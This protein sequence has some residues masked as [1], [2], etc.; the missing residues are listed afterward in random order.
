MKPGTGE[1]SA[2]ARRAVAARDW[3]AVAASANEI[4][5]R[6]GNSAEGHFL[7]GLV[8][9]ARGRPRAAE[10]AFGRALQLD[11]GRHDAAVELAGLLAE[12][13]RCNEAA[14]LLGDYEAR[15]GGSPRYLDAAGMAYT[16]IGLHE[17][18]YPLYARANALQ[19]GIPS[20]Q[21]HLASCAVYV[22]R[23]DQARELYRSLLA[24]APGHQRNHYE[25]SQLGPA[26]DASH[27]EEMKQVLE[28]G[29]LP[30][31][32]NIFLYYAI[33][34]ELEDLGQWQEAFSWYKRAGDAVTAVSPYRVED[35]LAVMAKVEEACTAD[36]LAGGPALARR[37]GPTPIFVTG[38][39]RTGTTL[40]DRILASH[41]MV[42][43]IGETFFLQ[44]ALH[45][46]A[47]AR[48]A[49]VMTPGIVAAAAAGDVARIADTYMESVGYKLGGR[50]FF[51]DKLP[52]NFLHLGFIARAFPQA[53]LVYLRRD[54][55][56]ACFAMY[57]Q[58]FFRF[59]YNLDDLARY[60]VAHVRL[61][62]HWR[63]LLGDRLV[64]LRY[65]ALV[66]E[67]GEEVR[68][69]LDRLGLAFEPACLAFD[70]TPG[71]V[72]TA[73]S[74]QVREKIHTRSV[75]RW[76]HFEAQLQ[77]LRSA[78]EAAGIAID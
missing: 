28:S 66:Q 6:D 25:L 26:R 27:V 42:E 47:G 49:E 3:Q 68:T 38:L 76:R 73:S 35:D 46:V 43:S 1:L 44:A 77:P 55:M 51:V 69:L 15:L 37:H 74:A 58:S 70:R 12:S 21:A 10:A 31:E 39:P 9:K 54:P 17:R 64:E 30:P 36:W 22:G 59:A 52:E 16:R 4:L 56:D 7:A 71:A 61:L 57:K 32:R 72:A 75:G 45:H 20:I 11:A 63:R 33:G 2:M 5:R 67:P 8:E 65:E 48:P 24:A 19:P 13:G 14:R 34:K 41:S 50:P 29:G 18:A 23:I 60:Y 78:L 53:R 40:T 62:E